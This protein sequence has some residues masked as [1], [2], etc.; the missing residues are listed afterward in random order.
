MF[1][2]VFLFYPTFRTRSQGV[3]HLAVI[4]SLLVASKRV[5]VD[6][7]ASLYDYYMLIWK[8][9]YLEYLLLPFCTFA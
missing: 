7:N 5:D 4:T 6:S 3:I 9:F 2:H 1:S 8:A